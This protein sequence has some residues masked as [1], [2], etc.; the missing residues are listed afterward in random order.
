MSRLG[1]SVIVFILLATA[2]G[3][4][5]WRLVDLKAGEATARSGGAARP[6]VA[7]EVASVESGRL[8]EMRVFS[9]ALEASVRFDVAAK[10]SG[11]I[12][13]IQVDLGDEVQRGQ[14]VA[15][16]DDDEFVQSLAQAE[17]ELAVR[18]AE[19]AQARAELFRVERDYERLQSLTAQGVVSDTE[20]DEVSAGLQSQTAAVTLAQARVR[21]VEATVKLARIELSYTSVR[22]LWEGGPDSAIVAERYESAGNN[23]QENAPVLNLVGLDPLEAIVS[24]SESDYQQLHVGQA[25]TLTT[26]ARPGETFEARI[27]RIAPVFRTESR[28]ARVELRVDNPQRLLRP[29]MFIRVRLILR[30]SDAQVI[31]PEA[32]V[33]QRGSRRV[34]YTLDDGAATVTEHEVR[35]GVA[36]GDRVEILSPE[37]R[38]Q[39][40]V[41]GQHLLEQ[42]AAVTVAEERAAP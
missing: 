38:G 39:V 16:I 7:V 15:T 6:A 23:V 11:L 27:A 1:G 9:G 3:L 29:G 42:G 36:E 21:Q 22:G 17:A 37:L 33:I 20:L 8:R 18:Q 31:V 40:V 35:C 13:R 24:V 5:A 28:Q 19:V 10:V 12:E 30:E 32:A 14:V 26:D 25:A 4:I 2:A 34:V 41:M